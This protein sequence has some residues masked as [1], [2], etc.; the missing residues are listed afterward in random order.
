MAALPYKQFWTKEYDF[1]EFSDDGFSVVITDL[2]QA[3][4]RY[5]AE[6]ERIRKDNERLATEKAEAERKAIEERKALEE[7]ARKEREESEIGFCRISGRERKLKKQPPKRKN[8]K[9]S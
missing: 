9:I 4:S 8:L 1:R 5:D 3:K 7:K 6:Q 2:K